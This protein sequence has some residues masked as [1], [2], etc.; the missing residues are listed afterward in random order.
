MGNIPHPVSDVSRRMLRTY[1]A[2]RAYETR[3]WRKIFSAEKA[4]DLT[5]TDGSIK[6]SEVP[7]VYYDLRFGNRCNLKCRM[8][9]PTDSDSWYSEHIKVWGT[10]FFQDTHGKV[11]LI[12][13]DNGVYET[14]NQD[15]DW[16]SSPSFWRQIKN[17]ASVIRHIHTVGGEPLLIDQHYELLSAIIK[18]GDPS[19]VTI[20][21]NSNLTLL[22]DKALR[23]WKHF[24]RINIG[25]SI[26]G[27]RPVNNYI[28]YPS[29]FE[30]IERHLDTIDKS[31]DNV[32]VWI[33][34]TVSA[35]NIFYL[36]NLIQW[37][38][39][40]QFVKVNNIG[41][42][43][44]LLTLHPLYNPKYLNV[45][46]LPKLYKVRVMKKFNYFLNS[47]PCDLK[48]LGFSEQQSLR[49]HK[50][51]KTLLTGYVNYMNSED[52]SHLIPSFWKYTLSL[53]KI[54]KESLKDVM[55]ELYESVSRNMKELGSVEQSL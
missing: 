17:N 6:P 41:S 25:V 54:R 22:P 26:D 32:N 19:N 40:K 1:Q 33:A 20:E 44:P 36:T 9:G 10:N 31:L 16:V 34:T 48:D 30:K 18:H 15:Y 21:Y 12:K 29:R 39:K 55:P 50:E 45:K 51:A 49:L 47:F 43:N 27:H 13:K 37:R 24:K 14:E 38:M 46:M 7:L 4:R 52:W 8:C 3:N 5:D 28:R 2:R 23:L 42:D 53:D 11:K 35:Y